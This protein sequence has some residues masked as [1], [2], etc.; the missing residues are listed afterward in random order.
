MS[1]N[2]V[3]MRVYI[4]DPKHP[5]FGESGVMT[6]KVISLFG[7]AMAE[8]KLDRCAHGTDGC[9]V[10]KGQVAREKRGDRA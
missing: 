7:E 6:G 9:F 4:C 1:E 10:K 3:P 8:V 2:S 5:H